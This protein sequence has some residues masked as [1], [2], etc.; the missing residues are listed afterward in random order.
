[1]QSAARY[2][3]WYYYSTSEV[4]VCCLGRSVKPSAVDRRASCQISLRRLPMEWTR[5]FQE[6][7]S[8]GVISCDNLCIS[9]FH[10][11]HALGLMHL[12]YISRGSLMLEVLRTE[13]V[14]WDMQNTRSLIYWMTVSRE[15]SKTGN[16]LSDHVFRGSLVPLSR[17][18]QRH[19]NAHGA[20]K[21]SLEGANLHTYHNLCTV[22]VKISRVNG[23]HIKEFLYSVCEADPKNQAT[24][25]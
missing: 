24:D 23:F 20:R 19:D 8:R 12:G 1:V 4:L 9:P 18:S 11:Q 2:L 5:G 6:S 10:M 25:W 13:Q 15:H 3:S 21:T 14:I 17:G 7:Y 22:Q 16:F